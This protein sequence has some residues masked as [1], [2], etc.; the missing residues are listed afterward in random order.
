MV[1]TEHDKAFIKIVY[2]IIGYGLRKLMGDSSWQW[3]KT[4][5]I[6]QPYHEAA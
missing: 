4:V 2:L 1:I 5:W 3:V 6:G